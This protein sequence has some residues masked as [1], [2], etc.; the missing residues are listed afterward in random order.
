M[1]EE[2]KVEK[3][4]KKRETAEDFI[5]WKSE[6]GLLEVVDICDKQGRNTKFKVICHKCKED[7]EL[8][9]DD[10]FVSQKGHLLRGLKPCGCS[11]KPNWNKDQYLVL[12][13]RAGDGRFIVHG[14]SE[15]F[16]GQQTKLTLECLVDGNKWIVST[17]A[18]IKGRSGCPKCKSKSTGDRL[19]TGSQEAF[20]KCKEICEAERYEPIGFPYRYT[21]KKSR[22]EYKY[23]IHGKQNVCYDD[24]VNKGTRC[25]CCWKDRQK[26]L[27]SGFYGYYPERKDEQ[28][29]LYILDFDGKFLKVGRSFDVDERIKGL[30]TESKVPIKRIHKLRIFT[31]TH[32]EIYNLEQ[33]LHDELRERNFQHYVKWSKE[34]FNNDCLFILNKFLDICCLKEVHFT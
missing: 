13:R 28:E 9:P 15:K 25:K 12:A 29:Y 10:Y 14:F 2:I 6:D 31:A 5:G 24:F 3:I 21:N 33:E 19:R 1:S 26:E 20:D 7:P 23:P 11:K 17:H 30:R 4:T 18:T 34:C 22:F 16:Y 32:Q 8:F 27:S